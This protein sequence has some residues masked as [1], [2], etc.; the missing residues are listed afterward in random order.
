MSARGGSL[1]SMGRA[2]VSG[3][4]FLGGSFQNR[5]GTGTTS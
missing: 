3:A 2:L 1:K 4:S 5:A